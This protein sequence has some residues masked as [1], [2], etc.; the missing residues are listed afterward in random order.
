VYFFATVS[1]S[2]QQII[3]YTAA[4]DAG[5]NR[6]VVL[7]D[8]P[9]AGQNHDGGA[10]GFGPDGML[11]WAIGDLGN[12]SGVN[13]DLTSLAA[14][15]GRSRPD[16][17]VPTDN[18]FYDGAGPN[19]DLIWARGFRNPYTF[20]WRPET[21]QLWVN[22]VGTSYEQTFVV[23]AGDH[24]GYNL[25]ENNQPAGF[26]RPVIAYRTNAS[27]SRTIATASRSGGVATFT[28]TTSNHGFPV[29]TKV[30]IAGVSDSSFN[31]TAYVSEVPAFNTFR[32]VQAG[33]DATT[34][35]G[36]ATSLN[37]GGAI[38][39]GTFFEATSVPSQYRGDF[40]FGDFNSNRIIRAD[41]QP[42]GPIVSVDDW[43]HS[44]AAPIDMEVGPDGDLYVVT[45]AGTVYR[46]A[47]N[48]SSQ[49]IV[50]SR[51]FLRI[52]EGTAAAFAV[53]LAT[54]P[55]GDVVVAVGRSAGDSELMVT[56]GASLTF[57]P[58][59]W[60]VPQVVVVTSAWDA[61]SGDHEASFSVS[62]PGIGS[63][64]VVVRATASASPPSAP[65][66]PANLGASATSPTT[67][68]LTWSPAVGAT[69]YEIER[70]AAGTGF[71]PLAT[72]QNSSYVDGS[73]SPS[74]A[75]LY[76]VRATNGGGTS[77]YGNTDLATTVIFADDPVT[78][79]TTVVRAVHVSQLRTA[80]EAVVALAG[81]AQQ[82]WSDGSLT[83]GSTPI[84]KV[85][86]EELRSS[87]TSAR[88]ALAL[89]ALA[90]TDPV[91]TT[92]TPVRSQ[93]VQELRDGVD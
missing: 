30:T 9:T 75:Y 41:I 69:Q 84:R 90:F 70:A 72:V 31:G 65:P 14:K 89:P 86:V 53:R 4:G 93:H 15:V 18:P 80:V 8:L 49:G 37:I 1:S 68:T 48:A 85:H 3:R 64:E 62:S 60:S 45:Y 82:P 6:T 58:A 92:A 28:I 50:V 39:G 42:G 23:G 34:S 33:P 22:S 13:S 88:N 83:A 26:I 73:V 29:G 17:S 81:L 19:H 59:N 47:F 79:G 38:T 27:Q 10:V 51:R 76:R 74:T 40:F 46:V 2:E 7:P 78:A 36:T 77:P 87:L 12:G 16:G 56:Q 25:Y 44:I 71:Q 11:Y 54:A 52:T 63:E 5:T 61:T 55:V 43:A 67:V 66:A 20:T 24:A 91:L 21:E 35:G 32:I 57:T